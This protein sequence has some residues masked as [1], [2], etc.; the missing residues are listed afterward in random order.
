MHEAVRAAATVMLAVTIS[1]APQPGAARAAE[2]PAPPNPTVAAIAVDASIASALATE[3]SSSTIPRQTASSPTGSSVTT[4]ALTDGVELSVQSPSNGQRVSAGSN[5]YGLWLKFTPGEQAAIAG[6]GG[7][8]LE[9]GLCAAGG[10][11]TCAVAGVAIAAV[12]SYIQTS[13]ICGNRLLIYPMN[14]TRNR[15][16]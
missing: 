3:L 9:A 7:A 1:I 5:S 2:S 14:P 4:Y 6:G 12:V 10:L 13:G 11:V 16:A 15:C 8:L